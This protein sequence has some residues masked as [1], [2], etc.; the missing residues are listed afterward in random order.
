MPTE[1]QIIF[2][3]YCFYKLMQRASFDISHLENDIE[4]W[5][6]ILMA[7]NV[8]EVDFNSDIVF[9]PCQAM[10]ERRRSTG[11]PLRS[12]ISSKDLSS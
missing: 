12:A 11:T 7:E 2:S 9:S 4:Q 3:K 10:A 5:K 8:I 1:Q 6:K